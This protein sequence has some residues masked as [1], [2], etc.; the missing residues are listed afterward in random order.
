MGNQPGK[1]VNAAAVA[2]AAPPPLHA[3]DRLSREEFERR[4]AA[5][6]EINKAELIQG[7]VFVPAP[8]R[9]EQHS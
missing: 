5:H 7:V 1:T 4:Y 2:H 3:G 6:P 8:G 9:I